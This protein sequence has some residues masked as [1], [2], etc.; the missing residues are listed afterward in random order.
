MTRDLVHFSPSGSLSYKRCK[1]GF[2][3]GRMPMLWFF[4]SRFT[5]SKLQVKHELTMASA[6]SFQVLS[7]Y[8]IL[9]L[10][11]YIFALVIYRFTLHPLARFPGPKFAAATLW[12]VSPPDQ[13]AVLIILVRVLPRWSEARNLYMDNTRTPRIV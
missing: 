4:Y 7:I 6:E 2:Q 8:S 13:Q 9:A 3:K 10:S 1:D 12:P 11:I 5:C